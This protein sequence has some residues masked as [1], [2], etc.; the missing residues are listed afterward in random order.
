MAA[1]RF[2]TKKIIEHPLGNI[3]HLLKVSDNEF[4][5]FGEAY[6]SRVNPGAIKGWKKHRCAT[7]NLAAINGEL[8]VVVVGERENH[9]QGKE[10]YE[11]IIDATLCETQHGIL[12]VPPGYWVAF[13]SDTGADLL[14][15]STLAHDPLEADTLNFEVLAEFW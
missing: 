10:R 7:L 9:S 5:A 12:L 4:T 11:K 3:F 14:N 13:G 15:L 1:P 2:V 8:R 6:I